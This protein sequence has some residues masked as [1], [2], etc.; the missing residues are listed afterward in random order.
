MSASKVDP[1]FHITHLASG[2]LC[3]TLETIL[4]MC[5]CSQ[6]LVHKNC[7]YLYYMNDARRLGPL[8]YAVIL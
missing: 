6:T 8:H 3:E 4:Y 5:V 7:N 1:V 2:T